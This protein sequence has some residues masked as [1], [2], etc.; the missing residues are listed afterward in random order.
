MPSDAEFNTLELFVKVMKSLVDITEAIGTEK[1]VT[2]SVVRLLFLKFTL[3]LL[4]VT[5]IQ[6]WRRQ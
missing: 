5:R 6:D 2:I 3:S 1:W 4:K